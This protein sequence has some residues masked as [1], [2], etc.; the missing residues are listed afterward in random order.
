MKLERYAAHDLW[1]L[2][3]PAPLELAASLSELDRAAPPTADGPAERD[4]RTA[5][6]DDDGVHELLR[7]LAAFRRDR[8]ALAGRLDSDRAVDL[9]AGDGADASCE[10]CVAPPTTMIDQ[11]S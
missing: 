5:A 10:G 7:L 11:R 4:Q 2:D 9:V 6:R 1:F 8:D 3:D